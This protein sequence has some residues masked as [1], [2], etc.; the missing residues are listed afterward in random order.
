MDELLR[1]LAKW[2]GIE[3]EPGSELQFELANFPTGGL[4]LLVL[5]GCALV[6]LVVALLY[7]RDGKSLTPGQRLVLT[8][9]RV[10]A[11][12]AVVALL[13]EPNLVTVK[14]E[15]RPGHTLLLVDTSQSMTHVDAWRRA[16][17]QAAAD[18]W[19]ALGVTD[20]PASPRLALVKALLAHGDGEVV[21]KLAAKNHVQLYSF[22]GNLDQLPLLPPP[23]PKLGPDG[24]PLPVDPNAPVPVPQLDLT[25]L[26]ADGRASN[27]GGALRTALDKSRSAEIAA[28]VFV[29]DGRRNAGPQAAEIARLLNQRKIPHTFVLGIGD[30]SETQTVHLTRFEA[31][32][33]VFQKDPFEL[34][35][36]VSAQGYD[37]I[38]ITAK[39]LRVDDKGARQEV[40]SQ[41]VQVGGD[42][43]EVVIEWKDVTA[44]GPGRFVYSTE[45]Q[46]PEGEPVVAE[47]HQK[48]APVE[49]LGEK[50]RLLLVSGSANHEFQTLRTVLMRDKTID[51][52]SWLQSADAKFPQDGDEGVRIDKL[53]EE[54]TEF[55]PYDVVVLIDP[56]HT[57]LT[58]RF[59]ENLQKHVV[60]N[61][62][63]LWWVAGE[64]FSM[65][66]MRQT[67]A[68][69]PIAELLPIVPDIEFAER[70]LIGFGKAFV[71]VWPYMLAP[72]GD[73]GVGA[74]ITRIGEGRDDS[75][76]LWG[77]LPGFRFFFP[78]TRL[79]PAA[80]V[81]AE[82]TSPDFRRG[83][84]GMPMIA[85]QN[86]GAGRVV[87][88][89]TDETNRWRSLYEQAYN[90][91]WINGIR[92]LL[93][94][95]LQA[96]NSRL[97]LL[98]SEE[99]VDLG[100]AIEL[101][102]EAKDEALQPIAA[103]S[104][105]VLVERDGEPAET[106]QL[107]PVEGV[108]GS[109]NKRLRP[110]QLGTYR[111]RSAEKVGKNVEVSFQVVAAQI[112]RPGPMDRA[113]LAAVAG[114]VGGELFE[115]PQ[116]LLAA[117]DRI[118]SRTATD[119]FR[120]PHALWDGWPTIV[121]VLVLLSIEWLL[122]KRFNLL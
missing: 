30:P 53:P 96:G 27:L 119:T 63:G 113:E 77:R 98:A 35:A 92:Y 117:L 79:K 1:L 36:N 73:D 97:R 75:K 72:E 37:T 83:G 13:L 57:K 47:R 11:V 67:S 32:A 10:L 9:L 33:K 4:G 99:K 116:A 52:S 25:K 59:C 48:Q 82:H 29:S 15:T 46:P 41:Q 18:G 94:G 107:E 5:L 38:A 23:P 65:E 8:A 40:R 91:Y 81:L 85:M 111:V 26:S 103:D 80:I 12:L 122:R 34:K 76:L 16:E 24:Q 20:L 51:V 7:R 88:A 44:D 55:D 105:A 101:T 106:L 110:T 118:P 45:I 28:V 114:T 58:P 68:T 62:C 102:A 2:R 84:R 89:G 60:E 64:K 74:K 61:G 90:R 42:R 112:E 108:P 120:T 71:R 22:A 69:W 19:R 56:D 17:V 66:A 54:R 78:V 104:Y 109:F 100:D 87:F 31:P 3:P 70:N 50:L 49:V 121:V 115:T 21:R 39:L 6:V 14:R 43:G 86:V 95:R 93:E